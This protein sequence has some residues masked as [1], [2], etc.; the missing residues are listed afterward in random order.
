MARGK[1]TLTQR[2]RAE[3]RG[4]AARAGAA[5]LTLVTLLALALAGSADAAP[6]SFFGVSPSAVHDLHGGDFARMQQGKVGAVR[7][8]LGWRDIEP[9][10]DEFNWRQ[11]DEL[12]SQLARRG[13]EPRP[14]VFGSP[15]WVAQNPATPPRSAADR[16][17]FKQFLK[18]ILRRYGRAGSFWE[19]KRQRAPIRFLQ[20]LNEVNSKSFYP[21]R[22]R[23]REYGRLLKDS[24][25]AVRSVDRRV[26]IVLAGMF[27]TPQADVAMT[28]WGYLRKLYRV[29]G[30]KRTFDGVAAHPYSPTLGGVKIQLRKLRNV[31]KKAGDRRAD[32]WVTEIGAGSAQGRSALELGP[33]GQARILKRS[34][35]LLR[36]KRRSWNVG[37]VFWYSWLD[38]TEQT[39]CRWCRSAGLFEAGLK[40]KPAWQRY[41]GFTG[42]S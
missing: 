26:T 36:A 25:R 31:M 38:A 4:P 12:M 30:I 8:P 6:R 10:D 39:T 29:K 16:R 34:F 42:G 32:L 33:G 7:F 24:A 13:L 22:P 2:S 40:P 17:D 9:R 27:G 18:E 15:L 41:T 19:G 28:A 3:H 14:F 35:E 37:G 23:P 1:G 5:L 21:P 11:S 20:I